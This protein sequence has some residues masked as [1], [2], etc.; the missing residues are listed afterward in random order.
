MNRSS[1]ATDSGSAGRTHGERA[2]M[3]LGCALSPDPV[4]EVR[5]PVGGDIRDFP[6]AEF[7]PRSESAKWTSKSLLTRS[8][9]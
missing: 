9:G 7:G 8:N 6:T 5:P 2:A 3:G 1:S 4:C